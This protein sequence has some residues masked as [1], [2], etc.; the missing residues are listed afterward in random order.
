MLCMSFPYPFYSFITLHAHHYPNTPLTHLF[1][2]AIFSLSTPHCMSITILPF[3][4]PHASQT[5]FISLLSH[6]S[7]LPRTISLTSQPSSFLR[8]SH[9]HISIHFFNLY[10]LPIT[11][12]FKHPPNLCM[13]MHAHITPITM[14]VSPS[15]LTTCSTTLK[16]HRFETP[17]M[18][19]IECSLKKMS[20]I[21]AS[22]IIS[23]ET[24]Q[25]NNSEF[26]LQSSSN[27]AHASAFCSA[28]HRVESSSVRDVH[29][30]RS[31]L[32]SLFCHDKPIPEN[33]IEK[34]IHLFLAEKV[35]GNNPSCIDCQVEE[36]ILCAICSGSGLYVDPILESQG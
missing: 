31:G 8:L 24:H 6:L 15:S 3:S 30:R 7:Y 36:A 5:H 9:T 12:F 14:L 33:I 35:I 11:I 10:P 34:P 23:P 20:L 32:E 4:T 13:A 29:R 21:E 16:W 26:H 19:S 2:L 17:G 1:V 28:S 25:G 22:N 18:A 27:I